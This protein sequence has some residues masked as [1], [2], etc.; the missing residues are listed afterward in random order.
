MSTNS[1]IQWTHSTVNFWWG[2]TKVSPACQH[3][4]AEAWAKY[5]SRNLFGT[6]VEWGDGKPRQERLEAARKD[7]I[8]LQRKAMKQGSRIRVFANSMA[9]WL[10]DQVPVQW[11]AFMLET[12]F[13]TPNLDWQL[14]TKR[15]EK[16]RERL[17][18]TLILRQ[19]GDPEDV[20]YF[21]EHDGESPT[22]DFAYWLNNWTGDSPPCNVWIGT[23]V[24]DQARAE[25]RIPALLS[26]PAR[27][28]FLSC[29]PLLSTL[30]IT[31]I[32]RT[33]GTGLMRPL[34]GRFN[35]IH[36]V[37]TGGESG[38]YARP[39]HPDWFRSL[40]DQ[41]AGTNVPFFFKQWGE[42]LPAGEHA[43]HLPEGKSWKGTELHGITMLKCGTSQAGDLLDSQQHHAFPTPQS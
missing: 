34:D 41:C 21:E 27:V 6:L 13:L 2:C 43:A 35:R 11:L 12:I 22:D 20:H 33:G 4:Y 9:D 30:D 15:P 17:E 28:R 10:D 16:F 23:T 25:Q 40:R 26:I 14:L 39:A 7:A 38:P 31:S 32:P 18:K 1:K 37:I 36:W 19:G 24:E 5:S 29:E 42:Y 8:A 3:C